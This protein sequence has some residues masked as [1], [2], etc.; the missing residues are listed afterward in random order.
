MKLA[1]YEWT[2]SRPRLITLSGKSV[3]L[4]TYCV[5]VRKVHPFNCIFWLGIKCC[6]IDIHL[7][8]T[9]N[10]NFI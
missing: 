10:E 3:L 8:N 4:A 2:D 1:L 7:R 6:Q 5:E 9:K